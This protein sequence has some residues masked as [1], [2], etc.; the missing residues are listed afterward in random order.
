MLQRAYNIF[1]ETLGNKNRLMILEKLT[2]GPRSVNELTRELK[3]DQTTVSHNLRRLQV[4]GFVRSKRNGK[5]SIYQAN[6]SVIRPLFKLVNFHM[7][8][9]C[10]ELCACREEELKQK[11]RR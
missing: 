1:F 4:T 7:R 8:C 11:L 5:Y 10:G 2:K 9:N 6:K 3:L